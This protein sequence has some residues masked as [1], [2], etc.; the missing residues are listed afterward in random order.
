[1]LYS[2]TGV[3]SRATPTLI[4][5]SD[6]PM[7][8][9]RRSQRRCGASSFGPVGEERPPQVRSARVRPPWR[10]V[11]LQAADDLSLALGRLRQRCASRRTAACDDLGASPSQTDHVQ[12]TALAS[13]LPTHKVETMSHDLAGGGLDGSDPAQSGEGGL[14]SQSLW[15]LSLRPRSTASR[16]AVGTDARQREQLGGDL[17]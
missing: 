12:R 10:R 15:G 1:M 4:H 7:V 8:K 2:L 17:P 5:P 9:V 6:A 14:A 3:S 16:L 13:R 11:A